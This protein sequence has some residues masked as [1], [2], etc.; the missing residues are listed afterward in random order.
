MKN[1]EQ[2]PQ[3][4]SDFQDYFRKLF[5]EANKDRNFEYIY[6]YLTRNCSY[7][8]RSILRSGDN[9]KFFIKSFSWL[10]ALSEKLEINLEEA[11]RK[12]FPDVCPYCI[13]SPCIC[14]E[15]S[16][17]PPSYKAE[18]EIKRELENKYNA[19]IN[20]QSDR[21]LSINN[22]VT[23]INK[24][25]PAN[26]AVWAAYGSTYHFSRLFE[27]IGEIHEAYGAY[28]SKE[29]TIANTRDELADVFAWLLSAWGIANK[30][31]PLSDVLIEHYY[32]GCPVC[33]SNPCKCNDYSSRVQALVRI[34]DL[35]EFKKL[36]IDVLNLAPEKGATL[37]E[38]ST[39]LD[40]V[41]ETKSTTEAKRVVAQGLEVLSQVEKATSTTASIASSI[42]T[43]VESASLTAK[44]FTW[45]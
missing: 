30:E 12:K 17:K 2:L 11:L 25:Y 45:F 22:A 35:E 40:A 38:I 4:V 34:E 44:A 42:K 28:A 21:Y 36:I 23:S 10:F 29:R 9:K 27:E 19:I 18:W 3:S 43:L 33:R 31:L 32:E 1:M 41:K 14:A 13:S 5:G 24:I 26:R 15:T 20:R 39:S 8:S 37:I 6:S 7:L 16:K